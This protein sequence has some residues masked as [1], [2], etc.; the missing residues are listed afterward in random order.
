VQITG[1]PERQAG[2]ERAALLSSVMHQCDGDIVL[3][4]KRA[5]ASEDGGDLACIVLVCTVE[6]N[7]G[8]ENQESRLKAFDSG[9]EAPKVGLD[10]EAKRRHGDDV[11]LQSLEIDVAV[12]TQGGQAVAHVG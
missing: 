2:L 4:L 3:A 10:I 5:K 7:Q 9:Y 8:I 6:P 1:P 12:L 11:N